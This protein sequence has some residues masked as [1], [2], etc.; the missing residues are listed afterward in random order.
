MHMKNNRP[1]WRNRDKFL[2]ILKSDKRCTRCGH[3]RSEHY[4]GVWELLHKSDCTI[5]NCHCLGFQWN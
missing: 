4:R 2:K 1:G 5:N 3:L